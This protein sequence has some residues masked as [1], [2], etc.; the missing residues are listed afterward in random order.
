[1][2]R[3][4]QQIAI[5]SRQHHAIANFANQHPHQR[6][7]HHADE[8]NT[9]GFGMVTEDLQP[10][11][12]RHP[13]AL[14][15]L[16]RK[17]IWTGGR[18]VRSHKTERRPGP[19]HRD[20]SHTAVAVQADPSGFCERNLD[21]PRDAI[22]TS[23]ELNLAGGRLRNGSFNRSRVI[24]GPVTDRSEITHT[25]GVQAS[26]PANRQHPE[27]RHRT[28]DGVGKNR[29]GIEAETR[30]KATHGGQSK[31]AEQEGIEASNWQS[32]KPGMFILIDAS[33]TLVTQPPMPRRS[34]PTSCRPI[35]LPKRSWRERSWSRWWFSS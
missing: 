28:N 30:N 19:R 10:A 16:L 9:V 18:L 15:S 24:G 20:A 17:A 13:L 34:A 8:F 7:L 32:R 21:R 27:E 12:L 29:T 2:T 11:D 31:V 23:R 3:I 14:P 35:S 4:D 26:D 6:R 22:V 25:F 33:A 1:M 5:A